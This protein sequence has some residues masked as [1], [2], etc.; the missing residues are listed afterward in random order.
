MV[1]TGFE[2]RLA[3]TR[4]LKGLFNKIGDFCKA[5][6]NPEAVSSF[7]AALPTSIGLAQCAQDVVLVLECCDPAQAQGVIRENFKVMTG[8]SSHHQWA[9]QGLHSIC[10][11]QP[12]SK[13]APIFAQ[14]CN[15]HHALPHA[16]KEPNWRV[17]K[18]LRGPK[19]LIVAGDQALYCEG[20]E[21]RRRGKGFGKGGC[22]RQAFGLET[23]P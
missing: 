3:G 18:L 19:L 17:Y 5:T 1:Q 21:R 8:A 13:G 2:A 12:S 16:P 7:G 22:L 10:P 14:I 4:L 20:R 15:R 23:V 9:H 11:V 6:Q